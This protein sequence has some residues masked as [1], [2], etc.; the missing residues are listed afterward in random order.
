[1]TMNFLAPRNRLEREPSDPRGGRIPCACGGM[2]GAREPLL[3][4]RKQAALRRAGASVAGTRRAAAAF[5]L[6]V[7]AEAIRL[8][9]VLPEAR[10]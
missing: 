2:P 4:R 5:R 10:A 7:G 9:L 3:A 1:M 6:A 8:P